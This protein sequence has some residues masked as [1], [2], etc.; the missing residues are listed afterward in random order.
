MRLITGIFFLL[1]FAGVLLPFSGRPAWA[2]SETEAGHPFVPVHEGDLRPGQDILS[3]AYD[4]YRAGR[5]EKA[6]ALLEPF[7]EKV[8]D[9]RAKEAALLLLSNCYYRRNAGDPK[10]NMQMTLK[11]DQKLLVLFPNSI[12][13]PRTRYRMA[14]IYFRQKMFRQAI[15]QYRKIL[16]DFP[17][18][19]D[20]ASVMFDLGKSMVAARRVKEGLKWIE[21]VPAQYPKDPV[22]IKVYAYLIRYDM[23][24]KQYRRALKRFASLTTDQIMFHPGLRKMYPELLYQLRRYNKAR[25]FFFKVLNVYPDDPDASLWSVRIGDIYHLENRNR[26]A[27]KI[28]YQT[29]ER[30]PGSE[31]AILARAGILDV[32]NRDQ[33]SPLSFKKVIEGYDKLLTEVPEGPLRGLVLMRK[34]IFLSRNHALRESLVLFHQFFSEY[35]ESPYRKQCEEIYRKAFDDRIIDLYKQSGYPEIVELMQQHKH[36][37]TLKRLSPGVLWKIA[38]SHYQVAFFHTAVSMMEELVRVDAPAR[39]NQTLLFEL[40]ES[41]LELG[42]IKQ[43]MQVLQ[44]LLKR[45]PKGPFAGDVYVLKGRQAFL[46]GDPGHAIAYCT[47]ALRKGCRR[48]SVEAYYFLGCAYRQTGNVR[49]ARRMFQKVLQQGSRNLSTWERQLPQGARFALGDLLYDQG[50]KTEAMKVYQEAV[51]L[52]PGDQNADWARYRMALIQSDRGNPEAALTT[53]EGI[54][55]ESNEDL[56]GLLIRTAIGEIRWHQKVAKVL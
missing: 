1:V 4:H 43:A 52:Y 39:K 49:H 40:G 47:T 25:N 14:G 44:G 3:L 7:V 41:H 26:D 35:P 54:R 42:Q 55:R 5:F 36:H 24:R 10:V 2:A 33:A 31:G 13:V 28:Y 37:L 46:T 11:T 15:F 19:P 16:H 51:Q 34:A 38:D 50:K 23:N 12:V 6:A 27:L 8:T 30:F 18:F 48:R 17:G 32:R 9:A 20:S 45:F 29:R 56:L 21:N 22:I 53:L